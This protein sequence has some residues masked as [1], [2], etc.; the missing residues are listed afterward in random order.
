M[1]SAGLYFHVPFCLQKCPYCNFY[2]ISV[3]SEL[4][5]QYT[6][7]V[8]R[9]LAAYAEKNI[10]IDTVYFGGGTPSLLM[11]EQIEQILSAVASAFHLAADTEIT[12]EANPATVGKTALGRLRDCG[13]N[14][15]SLGVQSLDK[16]QLKRLGRLHTAEDAIQMV[17]DAASAG[18]SNISCD[19]MLALPEQTTQELAQTMQRLTAL[20]IT[21][22]SAYL[23]K[24][25][26][27][28]PFSVQKMAEKCPDGDTAADFYLQT[29]EVL[30]KAGFAQY[31]I[32]N[33]ARTGFE[34]R[35]NCKYWHCEPYL[36]IGPSAHSCWNGTRFFVPPSLP[37]FLKNGV[38]PTELEDANPCTL[39]EKVMLGLRLT[40]GIP[41]DW[42]ASSHDALVRELCRVGYLRRFDNRIAMT[43]RGF[44]VSNSI[45][46]ELL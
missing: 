16:E 43:P 19:L 14:R 3:Q 35:H 5:E 28:T 40:E 29:V 42:I 27:G 46:S 25:E 33:F 17:E 23:L 15:L 44:L 4:L 24:V 2:S 34:S 36:G 8:C 22:I 12:L 20:P 37:D 26:L 10:T 30:E 39:A 18:F 32:S 31:E 21:H 6:S 41:I 9:N 45:L 7:A 13:V 11:P 1:S 38:Q